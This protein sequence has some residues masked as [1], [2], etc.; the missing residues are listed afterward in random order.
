MSLLP[1]AV[2]ISQILLDLDKNNES[3]DKN[4]SSSNDVALLY[5]FFSFQTIYE[6][7]ELLQETTSTNRISAAFIA[8]LTWICQRCMGLSNVHLFVLYM[9]I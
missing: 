1:E 4:D 3:V 6:S 9:S 7:S 8:L 5:K 2:P